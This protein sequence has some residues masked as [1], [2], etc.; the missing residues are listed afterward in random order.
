M[1]IQ[2]SVFFSFVSSFSSCLSSPPLLRPLGVSVFALVAGVSLSL[3]P[4][5]GV[6]LD[7]VIGAHPP[8]PLLSPQAHT[9]LDPESDDKTSKVPPLVSITESN[10]TS[11]PSRYHPPRLCFPIW[12]L[13]AR[14][15]VLIPSVDLA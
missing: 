5:C 11:D 13:D 4:F 8:R 3:V 2:I 9:A 14:R 10:S 6:S 1:A 12:F 7:T 15:M